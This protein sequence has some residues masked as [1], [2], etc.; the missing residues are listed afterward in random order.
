MSRVTQKEVRGDEDVVLLINGQNCFRL[1]RGAEE[2]RPCGIMRRC[3]Q[4][5][6]VVGRREEGG[7]QD[8]WHGG[9]ILDM[10][11]G[12]RGEGPGRAWCRR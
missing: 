4:D 11:P 9:A 2:Q 8:R 7:E 6:T 12:R 10:A 1:Y 3:D 5:A